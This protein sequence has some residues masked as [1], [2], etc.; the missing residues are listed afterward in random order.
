MMKA[1]T[2]LFMACAVFASVPAAAAPAAPPA[3]PALV[4]S[5]CSQ[6][7]GDRGISTAPLFPNLAGQDK[8][9]L[10]AQLKA[11]REHKRGDAHAQAYMWGMAFPLTDDVIDQVAAYFAALPPPAGNKD[12]NAGEV[13]LGRTIFA[14]GVEAQ[15]VPSCTACH[16]ESGAGTPAIPRLAGQHREYIASQLLAFRDNER[17]SDIMHANAEH[18]TDD[19]IRAVAAYLAAQ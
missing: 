4:S 7:H 19:Q 8:D 14:Q 6:C 12:Q 11:F 3:E 13:A 2:T 17:V 10:A 9:Y 18:L 15:G 16:G 1:L 5:V